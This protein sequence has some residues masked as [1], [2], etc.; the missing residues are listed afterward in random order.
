[1]SQMV[2]DDGPMPIVEH[3]VQFPNRIAIIDG[4]GNRTFEELIQL[5][6]KVACGLLNG[7]NDLNE[8][9][10]SFLVPQSFQ[11]PVVQWGIWRAGGIAVPL[12]PTH[13]LSEDK[14]II[15][16]SDS[17]TVVYDPQFENLLGPLLNRADKTKF[18]STVKLL[19]SSSQ[20][21]PRLA[22]ERRAMILY[23]SG[24]TSKS[25][26]AVITHGNINAQIKSLVRAWEWSE[27]DYILHVLP[28][29]HVHG[30]VNVLCCALWAG[31]KC[32]ILP[33]FDPSTVWEKFIEEDLTLFM[34]VPTIYSS[35]ISFFDAASEGEKHEMQRSCRKF[36]LMVSGSAALP[37]SVLEKW[38]TISGQTLLERY[39][40]T[41][42]G[43]A[44]SN[45]LHG[46]RRPGFVGVPLPGVEVKLVG[47]DGKTVDPNSEEPGEIYVKGPTVF[48]EYWRRPEITQEAFVGEWFKTGD[49]G[50]RENGYFRILGRRSLDI[51]KTGGYKV[52]ALEIEEALGEHPAVKECAVVGVPD[53]Y[54]GERVCAALVLYSGKRLTLDEL[55][56]WAK[57]KVAKYKVPKQIMVLETLPRNAMGKVIKPDVKTLFASS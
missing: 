36:R 39:G 24:T 57:D 15:D 26:G 29:H 28:L 4:S 19:G 30:I 42:I 17:E 8:S 38:R 12:S 27:N 45:P 37:T 10:V 14:Y 53:E 18:V 56:D 11:Y 21:L 43:M 40:M 2:K 35:L 41:E 6:R 1:M 16:D 22:E 51:I 34:A 52:S 47:D 33:K 23:T 31:A 50:V 5:S 46:R 20:S 25:K 49:V 55:K 54:W 13:P 44:L 9:R 32:Q 3:A 7:R 48:L